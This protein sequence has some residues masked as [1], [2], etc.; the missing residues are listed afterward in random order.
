MDLHNMGTCIELRR[1]KKYKRSLAAERGK[2]KRRPSLKKLDK[3]ITKLY[4]EAI[5]SRAG[6][7][8]FG[9]LFASV[10]VAVILYKG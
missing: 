9:N 8:D 6:N 3:Q 2:S 10:T 4:Q 1:M 7:L 5:R